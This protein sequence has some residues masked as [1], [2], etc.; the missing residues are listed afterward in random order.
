MPLIKKA[1]NA[2]RHIF[3]RHDFPPVS[4]STFDGKNKVIN[5]EKVACRKCG[6]Q[7]WITGD[8]LC[9]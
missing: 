4:R 2:L 6:H 1:L 3:C 7:E 9:G 8:L 5:S